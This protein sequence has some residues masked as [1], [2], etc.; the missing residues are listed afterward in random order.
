MLLLRRQRREHYGDKHYSSRSRNVRSLRKLVELLDQRYTSVTIVGL[1]LHFMMEMTAVGFYVWTSQ[2]SMATSVSSF[3]WNLPVFIIE[4]VLNIIFFIEWVGVLVFEEDKMRYLASWS[5]LVNLLT[6]VPMIV[7]GIGAL[8]DPH[9]RYGWV[10]MYLRVSWISDTLCLLLDYPQIASYMVDIHREMARFFI[11]LLAVLGICIGTIQVVESFSGHYID[12]YNA[13]YMM[14]V[15]FDTLGYGDVTPTTTLARLFMVVMMMIGICYFLPLFYRLARVGEM[16]QYYA[17]YRRSRSSN[18]TTHVIVAGRFT[19]SAV[20][21]LLRNF[22]SG[23][24][25]YLDTTVVLMSST[26]NSAEVKLI[27]N[28]PFFKDRVKLMIGDPENEVDLKRADARRADAIFLLGNSNSAA[29]YNDYQVVAQSIAVG[30]F[31]P[32]LP[33]HLLLRRGSSLKLM[34]PYAASVLEMERTVHHL[35]GLS[36]VHPGVIPFI[37]NLLRTYE[38][39]STDLYLTR[40]WVEQYELSLR[41]DLYAIEV[42]DALRGRQLRVLARSFFDRDVTLIGILNARNVVQLNPRELMPNAKKLLLIARTLR[43]AREA[44]AEIARNYEQT[45]GEEMLVAPD[46]DEHM[47]ARQRRMKHTRRLSSHRLHVRPGEPIF[48]ESPASQETH[49]DMAPCHNRLPVTGNA[50]GA[51]SSDKP[52]VEITDA[53]DLENH[54]VVIDLSSAKA[55]DL[56]SRYANEAHLTAVANDVY[57]V[58]HPIRQAYPMNDIILL[59]TDLSFAPYF[60][61][62]WYADATKEPIRTIHGCGLNTFDLK[63]CNLLRCSGCCIFFAGDISRVGSTSALAMTVVL[64]IHDMLRRTPPFPLVVELEG[65]SNL[66][67]FPPYADDDRLQKKAKEDFV[68]EP[69][70]LIGNA[71]SRTMLYPVL[72]R[73]YFMEEF[74]DVMDVLISGY[75][76]GSPSLSRLALSMCGT[77]MVTYEDVVNYCLRVGFIPLA[78]HRCIYDQRNPAVNGQRFVM[79]NPPRAIPVH[80]ESDLIFYLTPGND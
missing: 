61:Y 72:Q 36:M 11:R 3:R 33:Q 38:P 66:P 47:L 80:Q 65:L 34:A 56:M 68:F 21:I 53:Y 14:I 41:N 75:G 32:E 71:I 30:H 4:F 45:F 70:F 9:F 27:A 19:D 78:I 49:A 6:S 5:T 51:N 60:E 10:P 46:P 25:K 29:Y 24:R 69:N 31:D 12:L 28:L 52:L 17:T 40:H 74:I 37:M 73:T 18:S 44:T 20:E 76:D 1:L 63:R 57:H 2:T 59:T 55:K 58:V 26:E 43:Q 8:S 42:P 64:S 23:W 35:I 13:M 77:E 39:L 7:L 22:Y 67:L 54:F 79:T 62:Y 15:T 50:R 48:V 16:R